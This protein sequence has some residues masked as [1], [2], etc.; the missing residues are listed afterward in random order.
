MG[1]G[2][3]GTVY[4]RIRVVSDLLWTQWEN[5]TVSVGRDLPLA[6]TWKVSVGAEL[7]PLFGGIEPFY[8]RLYYRIGVSTE[9][10]YIENAAGDTPRLTL[11][12][13][14]LGFPFKDDQRIDI[15]FQWGIRGNVDEF[16]AKETVFGIS[17]T[18]EASEKWFV[19]RR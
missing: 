8:N 19:R 17:I 10:H 18:I 11:V 2:F 6:D 3:S 7:Q 15:A 5:A 4:P 16:G 9:N 1:V 14:G 12:H 13:A